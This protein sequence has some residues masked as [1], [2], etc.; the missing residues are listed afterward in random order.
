MAHVK[1]N[2]VIRH[3]GLTVIEVLFAYL[4]IIVCGLIGLLFPIQPG[5]AH[6]LEKWVAMGRG[7]FIGICIL[8]V[9]LI[10]SWFNRK[11]GKL[12]LGKKT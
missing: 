1:Y 6:G 7:M 3:I 9:I 2:K 11:K 5:S 12:K 10:I 4:F 8:A